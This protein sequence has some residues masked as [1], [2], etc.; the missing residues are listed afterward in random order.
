MFVAFSAI[1]NSFQVKM[2][3]AHFNISAGKRADKGTEITLKKVIEKLAC[4]EMT[5][6]I[7]ATIFNIPFRLHKEVLHYS[8][9]PQ[10]LFIHKNSHSNVQAFKL[11]SI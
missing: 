3:V 2:L 7:T 6:A 5:E 10:C 4:E 8:A 9:L 11:F 1:Q